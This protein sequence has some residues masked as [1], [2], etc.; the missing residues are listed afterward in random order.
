MVLFWE[1]AGGLHDGQQHWYIATAV[2]SS[3]KDCGYCAGYRTK[4]VWESVLTVLGEC[5]ITI[6]SEQLV[7][8]Y[9]WCCESGTRAARSL[10]W[11]RRSRRPATSG[12]AARRCSLN[13]DT[14][15]S[16]WKVNFANP[17]SWLTEEAEDVVWCQRCRKGPHEVPTGPR[18]HCAR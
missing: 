14:S 11:C 8:H 4:R 18:G 12:R 7:I 6:N 13:E 3:S 10:S 1:I 17:L 15:V 5:S 9:R 16:F 2:C